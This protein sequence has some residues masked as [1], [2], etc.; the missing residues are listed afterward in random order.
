MKQGF[1]L[2]VHDNEKI[3]YSLQALWQAHR[4]KKFLDK[5]VSIV[6]D[7]DTAEFLN[8]VDTLWEEYFDQVII[9]NVKT[10]QQRLYLDQH[11]TFNNVDRSEAWELTPYDET[12]V[13]DT[14]ILIQSSILNNLWGYASDLVVCKTSTDLYG[15]VD[16]EFERISDKGVN[17]YWATVFYF[18]KTEESKIFFDQCKYVKSNYEWYRHFYSLNSGPIR[19]DFVWSIAL[20]N[21]GISNRC[22][23]IPWNLK[24]SNNSDFIYTMT[25][26][27]TRFLTKDGICLVRDQDVHVLNKFDLE[28][29]IKQEL[30]LQNDK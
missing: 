13:I 17:F 2:F 25:D 3:K 24:R 28:K 27:A 19:N 5:P 12:I 9:S 20:H 23:V 15:R 29:Q 30:G 7:S 10:S 18:K 26:T 11:L 8:T 16:Q 21:L 6:L 1:L 4:I 14:D 22:P